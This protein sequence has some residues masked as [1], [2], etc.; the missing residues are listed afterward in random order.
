MV[1]NTIF[2][3]GPSWLPGD[4]TNTHIHKRVAL[5]KKRQRFP[6]DPLLFWSIPINDCFCG[7]GTTVAHVTVHQIQHEFSVEAEDKWSG[8][9]TEQG[10][11][12]TF[13]PRKLIWLSKTKRVVVLWDSAWPI[14]SDG[15]VF[16]HVVFVSFYFLCSSRCRSQTAPCSR[17]QS[18]TV[19]AQPE[20]TS[21]CGGRVDR[22]TTVWKSI[23][24]HSAECGSQSVDHGFQENLMTEWRARRR[25]ALA[26]E[27][28]V[29]QLRIWRN[30]N[31]QLLSSSQTSLNGAQRLQRC[32]HLPHHL[33]S[34]LCSDRCCVSISAPV[35]SAA[36]Y[37][38]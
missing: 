18:F 38:S 33:P 23:Q 27:D 35:Y 29:Y 13:H 17:Q 6:P 2:L 34:L 25:A 8:A 16:A 20:D 26:E 15:T 1:I 24:S 32:I 3:H 36:D 30:T 19:T 7:S 31:D 10:V 14:A 9:Q 4:T 11:R 21:Y 5:W 12:N 28:L 37:N 22:D